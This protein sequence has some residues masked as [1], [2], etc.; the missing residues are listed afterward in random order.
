M[1][2]IQTKTSIEITKEQELQLKSLLG[3]AIEII[4][5]KNEQWLM[6]SFEDKCR[7]YFKGDC[8][9]PL[10]FVEVK[11][12]GRINPSAADRLTAEICNTFNSVLGIAPA[13]TYVK[14]EEVQ[15]WGWNGGNF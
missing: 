8:S 11:V 1:P 7:M 10:A 12:F 13:N 4:P 15:M 9:A 2:M 6:M 3:K 14:Y 5:G